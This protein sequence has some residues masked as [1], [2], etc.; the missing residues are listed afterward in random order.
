MSPSP[1]EKGRKDLNLKI[2]DYQGVRVGR[3][4]S[5]QTGGTIWRSSE[6]GRRPDTNQGSKHP[7]PL[8]QG[9]EASSLS[10]PLPLLVCLLASRDSNVKK[11]ISQTL[12]HPSKG[13]WASDAF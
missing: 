10:T 4:N 8:I 13:V 7:N 6:M 3:T 12:L 11:Y 2:Q 1:K 5:M 9:Y